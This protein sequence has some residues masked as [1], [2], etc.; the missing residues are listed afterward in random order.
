MEPFKTDGC[1][2]LM[3]WTWKKFT[4]HGPPWEKVCVEHDKQYY[5]GGT[6]KDRLNA[7]NALF[8]GVAKMGYSKWAIT[9]WLIVRLFGAPHFPFKKKWNNSNG[10]FKNLSYFPERP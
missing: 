8:V 10:R 5:M 1:S 6:K 9:M 7:D 3:S 2:G 4:G